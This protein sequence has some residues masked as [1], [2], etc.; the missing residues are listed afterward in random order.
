MT[1]QRSQFS[2]RIDFFMC[3]CF[4]IDPPRCRV[5]QLYQIVFH[6]GF[7]LCDFGTFQDQCNV[8]IANLISMTLH[9][10]ISMLN[11]FGRIAPF[12]SWIGILKDLSNVGQSQCTKNSIDHTVIYHIT[13]GM[14][15]RPQYTI[16]DGTLVTVLTVY[17]QPWLRFVINGNT[18]NHEWLSGNF[19]GCQTMNVKPMSNPNGEWFNVVRR[20]SKIHSGVVVVRCCCGTNAS[21]FVGD[22]SRRWPGGGGTHG[23]PE[24]FDGREGGEAPHQRH[25]K[26]VPARGSS[27]R[28]GGARE[29]SQDHGVVLLCCGLMEAIWCEGW[30][31]EDC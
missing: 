24:R 20:T 21:G 8:Q 18:G 14:C 16:V 4:E 2:D 11:K 22:D 9:D 30:W 7:E 3:S 17:I 28:T 19:Q 1:C 13:I 12:P 5:Q 15:D 29:G 27:T 31:R 10:R 23:D 6:S 25:D 26:K